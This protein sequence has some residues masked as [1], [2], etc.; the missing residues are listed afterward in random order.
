MIDLRTC[1][2]GVFL[3][4]SSP[5]FFQE[6]AA[7]HKNQAV[8]LHK[9]GGRIVQRKNSFLVVC[10]SIITTPLWG[11]TGLPALLVNRAPVVQAPTLAA[12]GLVLQ[13]PGRFFFATMPA[14][15]GAFFRES[16]P[17]SQ[18]VVAGGRFRPA[19]D[20]AF[21]PAPGTGI[22]PAP[23]NGF[24]PAPGGLTGPVPGNELGGTRYVGQ[25]GFF[26]RKEYGF[27]QATHIALRLRL[28]SL[29][30]CNRLEGKP[31]W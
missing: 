1:N 3:R 6:G 18:M 4:T 23:G 22:G 7:N 13:E 16:T 20:G 29:A 19:S 31:G 17:A 25:L 14:E 27:E 30:D 21:R 8:N 10:I 9:K 11:Q 5:I 28:G 2:S 26:C 12:G 15:P 24:E